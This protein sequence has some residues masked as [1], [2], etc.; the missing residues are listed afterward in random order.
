MSR[1]IL[2]RDVE[3]QGEVTDLVLT[4]GSLQTAPAISSTDCDIIEARGLVAVPAF[5]D[6][7]VHFRDPGLTEKEDLLTGARAAAAG[8]YT[9]VACEPNTRPVIDSPAA[10]ADFYNKT[11]ALD[12]PLHVWT[13]G[14]VSIGEAGEM[15]TDISTLREAHIAALSDDGE[16]IVNSELLVKAFRA[17]ADGT[18]DALVITAHCEE[19][20]RSSSKVNAVLG[21]GPAMRREVEIIRLHIDALARAGV[22]RLHIQH[23]SLAESVELIRQ[24]KERGLAVTAEAT[25]HHLLLCEEDIP[26]TEGQLDANWKMNPPLRSHDDMVA[27]R[28]ALADGIVDVIATDHAPHTLAE[29]GLG[30]D[31]APFG[32]I[33]LETAFSAC[34]SLV[35]DGTL[36]FKRLIEAMSSKPLSLLPQWAQAACR[37][38]I[39]L[40]DPSASWTVDPNHF[41]SKARNC[42]FTGMTFVGKVK[43]TICNGRVVVA[44]DNVLF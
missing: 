13:K 7:H 39:A 32:I 28:R 22:G 21:D 41:Y 24:A 31:K 18:D 26:R 10:V 8:G 27:L 16:P 6:I 30:W 23:V 36:T 43:Y 44:D 38:D 11:T 1:P 9:T 17:G 29:K 34:L 20:P 5:V 14:A 2:I 15:L 25:P 12:I 40:I 37:Y 19:T 4:A 3:Y 42:P 35:H 33:G